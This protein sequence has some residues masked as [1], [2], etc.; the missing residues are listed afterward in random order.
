VLTPHTAGGTTD[1]IPRMVAQALE[2]VRLHLAGEPVMS[3]V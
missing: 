1:S 2:N 3:P